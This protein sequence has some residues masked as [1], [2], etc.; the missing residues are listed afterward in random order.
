M[1]E[2]KAEN[3]NA[4]DQCWFVYILRCNDDTLYTGITNNLEKRLKTHNAGKA[5]KYTRVRLP[6][7]EI[8]REKVESK[9]EALKREIEIK[10]LSRNEKKRLINN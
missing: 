1:T 4:P 8:Y 5:S 7:E 9:S 3:N 2:K 10:K 6:V